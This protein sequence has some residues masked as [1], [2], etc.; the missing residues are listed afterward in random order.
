MNRTD[1][2]RT[3]REFDLADL[4]LTVLDFDNFGNWPVWAKASAMALLYSVT[5]CHRAFIFMLTTFISSW[6]MPSDQ[7]RN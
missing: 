3:L 6:P 4:D 5:I 2:L 7:N 1:L